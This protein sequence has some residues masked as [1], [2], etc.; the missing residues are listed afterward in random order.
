MAPWEWIDK[1]QE[2]FDW[3]DDLTWLLQ[4]CAKRTCWMLFCISAL[5]E[6]AG[7]VAIIIAM[8]S[9][10]WHVLWW[11]LYPIWTLFSVLCY[12]THEEWREYG[13]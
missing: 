6:V 3:S 1:L 13:V 9:S 11:F 8:T 4:C 10:P 2:R 5:G 12:T 7:A